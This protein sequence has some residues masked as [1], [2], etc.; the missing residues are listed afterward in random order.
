MIYNSNEGLIDCTKLIK[1]NPGKKLIVISLW[2]CIKHCKRIKFE[3]Y[4]YNS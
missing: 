4:Y 2:T 3:Y 1:V